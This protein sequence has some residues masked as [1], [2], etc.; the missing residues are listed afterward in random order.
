MGTTGAFKGIFCQYK[1]FERCFFRVEKS[2]DQANYIKLKHQFRMILSFSVPLLLLSFALKILFGYF[3]WTPV[4]LLVACLVGFRFQCYNFPRIMIFLAMTVV[5]LMPLSN[6]LFLS[7]PTGIYFS[8][9][10]LLVQTQSTFLLVAHLGVQ[11]LIFYFYG[12][13]K[14]TQKIQ[15]MTPEELADAAKGAFFLCVL[16]AWI[17]LASMLRFYSHVSNLLRKL[18]GLWD[19]ISKNNEKLN[20]QNL[21]LQNNLE[22]KDIFI[23][24]FSHELKNALNGLLGNLTLAYD[25]AKDTQLAQFLSSAKV[26]GEVLKNF[27][28]NI[29]DSGKLENGNLEV[30]SERTDVMSFMENVWA[31]CGRIIEN[32]R[33]Q[34]YL[35]IA[36]NVPKHLD[37]DEQRMIQIVLNLV[38]NAC[39]F[40]EK[41]HV[42][43]RVSWE[44]LT[45]RKSQ[46]VLGDRQSVQ[47]E[48]NHSRRAHSEEN[49]FTLGGDVRE[50]LD[51]SEACSRN[52]EKLHLI[53]DRSKKFIT[54]RQFYQLTLSKAHWDA[55]ERLSPSNYSEN[56]N[57]TLQVQVF[58]TGCGMNEEE[59]SRLF[60][61]FSQINIIP[62][63]RKVG[64]G[65]GLWICKELAKGLDGDIKVRSEIG[66]GSLFELTIHTTVSRNTD[67]ATQ[68][69][70]LSIDSESSQPR[71]AR[72]L[73]EPNMKKILIADDDNFNVELMKNYLNKFGIRY[74]CAYDGEEAVTLFKK[75]YEEICY[76]ITDNFMPKKTGVEAALE[77]AHFLKEMKKPRIPIM[78]I[79]G[80]VKVNVGE[81]GITSVIQKPINFERLKHELSIVYPQIGGLASLEPK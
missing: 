3:L 60:R 26:C 5:P 16:A 65:L 74:I 4:P 71:P 20:E 48:N 69:P 81:A 52:Q 29:L 50:F 34:G 14:I 13:E 47:T 24:T 9:I 6:N 61:R 66:V 31:I 54:E 25:T 10:Q 28:H 33:L 64:T 41:G 56:S 73:K 30:S 72:K 7:A 78:C 80:D 51:T 11:T 15:S 17:N 35:E 32:K 18:S 2:G 59:Q 8:S 44:P 22:M 43:I 40:T 68:Q 37:L 55:N 79:S 49:E 42:R 77:I 62:G 23:Y 12:M 76:I 57:G 58:D 1:K 39:K 46:Q 19:N 67:R 70:S 36:K 53:T 45:A 27:V 63:Q 75:H 38:S 21:K